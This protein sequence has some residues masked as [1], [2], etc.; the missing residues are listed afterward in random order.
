MPGGW[1]MEQ[2]LG[3]AVEAVD[4]DGVPR[5]AGTISLRDEG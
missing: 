5:Y 3:F 4:D 1:A 2:E